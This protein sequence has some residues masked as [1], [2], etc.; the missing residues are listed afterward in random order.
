MG[1]ALIDIRICTIN[2]LASTHSCDRPPEPELNSQT[3][4][5]VQVSTTCFNELLCEAA[6][7]FLCSL[8]KTDPHQETPSTA[9]N[10]TFVDE[11]I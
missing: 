1:P 10:Q 5:G 2:D 11:R 8:N 6:T 4:R 9:G 3:Q 7:A